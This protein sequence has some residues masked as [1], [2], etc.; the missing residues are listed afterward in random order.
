[1]VFLAIWCDLQILVA[2]SWTALCT[3]QESRFFVESAIGTKRTIRPHP[4]FVRYW[5]NSGQSRILGRD[6]LSPKRT[7]LLSRP[8]PLSVLV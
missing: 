6:G 5:S 8:I 4:T 1:L 3:S 2:A 7:L